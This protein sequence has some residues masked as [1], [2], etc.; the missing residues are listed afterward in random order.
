MSIIAAT[1]GDFRPLGGGGLE[2]RTGS[3]GGPSFGTTLVVPA[4]EVAC[5]WSTLGSSKESVEEEE[6]ASSLL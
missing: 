2:G 3:F 1:T 4:A 5:S 6:R